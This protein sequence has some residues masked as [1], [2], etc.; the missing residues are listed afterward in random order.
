MI[1][2][3]RRYKEESSK[4]KAIAVAITVVTHIVILVICACIGL[5]A[6]TP[7]SQSTSIL[8]EFDQTIEVKPPIQVAAGNEPKAEHPDPD[9]EIKLVQRSESTVKSNKASK[10]SESTLGEH[11]DVAKYEAPRK[12]PINKRALFSSADNHSDSEAAQTSKRISTALKAGHPEGN[13]NVGAV[14]GEPSARLAGRNVMGTLPSPEYR[15]NNEGTVVVTIRVDNY[16]KVTNA[17]PGAKGTTV[18]DRTLW[19]A[20]KAAAL[21]AHFNVSDSAP[22]IQE[23][24]ITYIFKLK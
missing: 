22:A 7:P 23:G 20:A 5:K 10:S 2:P 21:K 17:I 13:T 12:K 14:T 8:V 16:G 11:G 1:N 9:K 3:E 6:V 24:T 18:Q 15:V 4:S 19:N